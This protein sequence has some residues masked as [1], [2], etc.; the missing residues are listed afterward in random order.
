MMTGHEMNRMEE[1]ENVE[2]LFKQL[3]TELFENDF[4]FSELSYDT[5]REIK[6]WWYAQ[7]EEKRRTAL[8]K[9]TEEEKKLLKLI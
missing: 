1:L 5:G 4:E 6:D 9:L 2:K 3:V 8:A 7:T